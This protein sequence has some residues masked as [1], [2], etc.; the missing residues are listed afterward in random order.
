MA[1]DTTVIYWDTSA[2]LAL[3]KE[4]RNHG[5]GVFE[6][7]MAQAGSF[8]RKQIVLATSTVGILE[9]LSAEL[10]DNVIKMFNGMLLRSNFQIITNT[11]LIAR[12]AAMLRKHC[13]GKEKNGSQEN[14]ILSPPDAIHVASAMAIKADLLITL[15]S[16][17]KPKHREMAMTHVSKHYPAPGLHPVPIRRPSV[18]D[19]GTTLF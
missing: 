18:G 9:V 13:Y 5:A 16:E 1:G 8:D 3:M 19:L 14:Y 15:D 17:N 2:F 10:S 11:E 4:E 7:L 12:Q 6:A